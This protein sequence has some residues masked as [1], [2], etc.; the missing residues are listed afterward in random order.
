MQRVNGKRTYSFFNPNDRDEVR[1][2]KDIMLKLYFKQHGVMP[3]YWFD[4]ENRWFTPRE[5]LFHPALRTA[6]HVTVTN[7]VEMTPATTETVPCDH[8]GRVLSEH[9]PVD[10]PT[11]F[12]EIWG[13]VLRCAR[14]RYHHWTN[15]YTHKTVRVPG[16]DGIWPVVEKG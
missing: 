3:S 8:C 7:L 11:I 14:L 12:D 16:L 6:D 4:E 13:T 9:E 15:K 2:M 1:E 5:E 10:L